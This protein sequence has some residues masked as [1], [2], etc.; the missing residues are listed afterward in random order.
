MVRGFKPCIGLSAVS[1]EPT[2]DP[3]S[4]SLAAPPLLILSLKINLKK[5]LHFYCC[6]H[7][8]V[9]VI[10]CNI[11][12]R[13]REREAERGRQRIQSGLCA[14]SREPDVGLK[15][16]NCEI[17]TRAEVGQLT[18]GA[19]QASHVPPSLM[20]FCRGFFPRSFR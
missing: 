4:T 17:M 16:M 10:F 12:L 7:F 15:L 5:I 6:L 9:C 14:D 8:Y 20:P 11:Y 2:S 1:T 13:E 3:L 18:D 19:T